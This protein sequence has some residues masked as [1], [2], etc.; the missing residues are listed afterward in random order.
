MSWIAIAL[1]VL[2]AAIGAIVATGYLL[3]VRHRATRAAS[4]RQSPDELRAIVAD[5][6][7]QPAWRQGVTKVESLSSNSGNPTYRE[8]SKNGVVTY[9]VIESGPRR[10]V[11]RIADKSLP[12]GGTWT[13]QIEDHE[14]GARL[15]ITEDGEVYNPIFRALS[16]FVFGHTATID[17]YLRSLDGKLGAGGN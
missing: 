14:G 13:Y 15:R 12:F 17:A 7:G 11:T 10:I 4:Y 16:R 2:L 1:L 5:F 8:T 3:P 6:A 9:E